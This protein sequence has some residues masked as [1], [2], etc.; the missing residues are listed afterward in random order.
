MTKIVPD[1][2]KV[3]AK[4]GFIRTF[5]QSLAA[6][7]PTTGIAISLT[8]E[9]LHGVGLGLGGAVISAFLAGSA[10]YLSIISSGVPEDY[11]IQE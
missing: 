7:I 6:V 5:A 4:R 3:A 11:V 2:T 8:S 9:W 10:S 1:T